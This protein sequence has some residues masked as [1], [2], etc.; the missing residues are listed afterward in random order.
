[1]VRLWNPA[2]GCVLPVSKA[3]PGQQ[4]KN[5]KLNCMRKYIRNYVEGGTYFFTMVTKNR[6]LLFHDPDLCNLFLIGIDKVK[7]YHPFDLVAYC[8]LP[9]HIHLLMSLPEGVRDY[10][11]IIKVLKRSVTKSIRNHLNLPDLVV[12]QDRF[13]EHTIRDER[14][15]QIHF[16][17]ILYNPVKHGYV[18]SVDQWK[19]SSIDSESDDHVIKPSLEQIDAL[20]QK[21]NS[22]GE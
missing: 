7:S 3:E 5:D 21:G 8:I 12:W 18:E 17:Y 22:F 16:E 9:D 15:M 11:K 4:L 14:D 19:W 20:N 6:R 1:M 10:S 13:W 2:H